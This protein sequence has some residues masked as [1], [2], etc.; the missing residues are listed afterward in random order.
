MSLDRRANDLRLSVS[1]KVLERATFYHFIA[2]D[3]TFSTAEAVLDMSF[4]ERVGCTRNIRLVSASRAAFGSR[5]AG[6][7]AG[8]K[9]FS[10]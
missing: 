4:G 7:N 10:R 3:T 8:G 2:T 1:D 6:R 5:L 9:A